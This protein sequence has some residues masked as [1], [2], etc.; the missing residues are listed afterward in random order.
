MLAISRAL[1]TEPKVLLL[2]ELSMGLA[3][4]IVTELYELV[5]TLA[6]Q[7]MTILLVEQFVTTALS[8]ATRAAIMVHGRI[9]Q[10]GTPARDGRRRPQ[11]LPGLSPAGRSGPG[12]H[13]SSA[14]STSTVGWSATT[15][16]SVDHPAGVAQVV[17]GRAEGGDAARRCR[18]RSRVA[19]GDRI[20]RLAVV[21][22]R[23]TWPE[24][25]GDHLEHRV[26]AGAPLGERPGRTRRRWATA[27]VW[28]EPACHHDHTSSVT[29][30]RIGASRRSR[31]ERA[32]ARAAWAEA[33][34]GS[35]GVAVG[36][37]LDQLEVV[38]AEGPEEGLGPLEGPGVVV[39]LEGGG[40]LVDHLGQA[41][42]HG[43]VDGGG[44]RRR[45][46]GPPPCRRRRRSGPGRTA[47][48]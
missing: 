36:P 35:A 14:S 13:S 23:R 9:E 32:R 1:V 15:V 28:I 3:P 24:H 44:D 34:P 8:V 41:G 21:L 17:L 12:R 16:T 4:L 25:L 42:Q 22:A 45:A 46:R 30:G 7:G 38:V 20:D 37:G 10:E 31:T 26:G 19:T 29:K 11:R 47:R 5:G 43:P 18:S 2:D 48:R 40:G 6:G 33:G 39:V 27:A